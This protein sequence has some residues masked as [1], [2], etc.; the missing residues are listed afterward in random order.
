MCVCATLSLCAF[1][2]YPFRLHSRGEAGESSRHPILLRG[3]DDRD[4][5]PLLH[6][7]CP[8]LLRASVGSPLRS[9]VLLLQGYLSTPVSQAR[10]E[11]RV[12]RERRYCPVRCYISIR[13]GQGEERRGSREQGNV[14]YEL[15]HEYGTVSIRNQPAKPIKKPSYRRFLTSSRTAVSRQAFHISSI[16]RC[17]SYLERCAHTIYLRS[18]HS[19]TLCT[20]SRRGKTVT[21]YSR[22]TESCQYSHSGIRYLAS[23]SYLHGNNNGT[24]SQ[25]TPPGCIQG[26]KV[27]SPSSFDP[28]SAS[29]RGRADHW[30]MERVHD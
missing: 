2:W 10:V 17:I 3:V 4:D 23:T 6:V 22:T 24:C 13:R 1:P 20:P 28:F 5:C 27:Y 19:P 7:L 18:A 11:E 8:V 15:C 26:N 25:L 9:S 21:N 14:L 29:H 30:D 16:S 12:G